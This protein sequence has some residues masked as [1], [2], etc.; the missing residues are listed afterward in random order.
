MKRV[1]WV[2]HGPTKRSEMIGWTDVP[3][4]LDNPE[5]VKRLSQVLPTKAALVS[6]D[7]WRARSTADVIE[8]PLRERLTSRNGLREFNF[9]DWEEQSFDSVSVSD[10]ELSRQ[11]WTNPG[12]IAPN[13]GESWNDVRMRV[14]ETVDQLCERSMQK[15][16]ICV[17]HFGAILTQ[18]ARATNM[19]PRAAL[20]FELDH[21]SVTCIE[22]LS[23]STYRIKMVNHR[24]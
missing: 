12:D 8:T 22:Y 21:L 2:R 20:R 10:P 3:A 18:L 1:W 13:G 9:G 24:P 4:F 5:A 15:D 6:S 23:A 11:Y 17:S 14:D 7:L 16:I 19:E